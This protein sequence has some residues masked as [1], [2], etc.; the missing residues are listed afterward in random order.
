M[1]FS[2]EG[3]QLESDDWGLARDNEVTPELVKS[4]LCNMLIFNLK[5]D[6]K[7]D[8]KW[9][10]GF[11][12]FQLIHITIITVFNRRFHLVL[13]AAEVSDVLICSFA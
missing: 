4:W 3:N 9:K 8:N 11:N 1:D 5:Y 2:Q 7:L 12:K 13:F 10:C 6:Y